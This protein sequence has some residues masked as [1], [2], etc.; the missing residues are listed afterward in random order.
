MLRTEPCGALARPLSSV[1]A[2]QLQL[3]LLR[4]ARRAP[5]HHQP[6]E[7]AQQLVMR[8]ARLGLCGVVGH[9]H[10]GQ[11]LAQPDLAKAGGGGHNLGV[12]KRVH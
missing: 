12:E 5:L 9:S 3:L 10:L 4:L 7:A 6:P 11:Q 1:K 8:V 2:L